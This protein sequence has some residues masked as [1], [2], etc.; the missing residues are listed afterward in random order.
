[1]KVEISKAGKK[2][3][4]L[5][6]EFEIKG[7]LPCF[8]TP[9]YI[10][11]AAQADKEIGEVIPFIFMRFPPGKVNYSPEG[12]TLTLRL[13]NRLITLF[14]DGNIAV[15]NTRDQEEAKEVL[16]KIGNMINEAYRDYLKY[17]KPSVEEVKAA[18]KL[19]W[20]DIYN[21]LP[22]TNCGKCGY[23]VCSAFAVSLLQGETKLSKCIPMSNPEYSKNIEELEQKIGKR[24][25]NALG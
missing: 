10:R 18:R 25:L 21:H 9:G 17:G 3:D 20:M 2:K 19:S 5:V 24:L 1:M 23:Q 7:I 6:K 16:Q 8:A 15:T 11:F 14:P 22:K 4:V 12:G 13:F